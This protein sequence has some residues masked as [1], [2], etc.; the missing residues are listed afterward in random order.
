MSEKSKSE[1]SNKPFHKICD[2]AI[3]AGIWPNEGDKGR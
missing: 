2:N 1:Q 3:A